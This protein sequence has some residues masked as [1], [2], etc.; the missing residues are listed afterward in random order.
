VN[1]SHLYF[2]L[3]M[4]LCRGRHSP[5]YARNKKWPALAH[6]GVFYVGLPEKSKFAF[7]PLKV[8]CFH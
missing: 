2:T 5:I 7:L 6:A 1:V 8:K 3:P 4:L